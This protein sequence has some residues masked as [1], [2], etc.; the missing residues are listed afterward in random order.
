MAVVA[1]VMDVMIGVD[2]VMLLRLLLQAAA[3][4]SSVRES[5]GERDTVC[6]QE[7]VGRCVQERERECVYVQESVGGC[8]RERERERECVCARECGRVWVSWC[9]TGFFFRQRQRG[10]GRGRKREREGERARERARVSESMSERERYSERERGR[11]LPAAPPPSGF[12]VQVSG[13]RVQGSG[14]RVQG[15]GF[16]VQGSGF[17]VQGSV[18]G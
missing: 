7:S 15:P 3:R 5:V 9:S 4:P 14:F 6:V 11:L 8:V 17:R 12:R 13:F 10:Q 2:E 18:Q 16:R 1:D